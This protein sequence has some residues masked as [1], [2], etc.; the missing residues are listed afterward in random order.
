M[1]ENEELILEIPKN[2]KLK[3]P[4]SSDNRNMSAMG[5]KKTDFSAN[6]KDNNESSSSGDEEEKK[7]RNIS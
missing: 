3:S 1:S 6:L 2:A 5:R 4:M 7:N